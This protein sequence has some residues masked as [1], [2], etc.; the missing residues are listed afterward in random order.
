[1]IRVHIVANKREAIIHAREISE[2]ASIA[3][4]TT[5]IQEH[6]IT[7][8]LRLQKGED[9][10]WYISI[11]DLYKVRGLEYDRWTTSSQAA[12]ELKPEHIDFLN[13][14]ERGFKRNYRPYD[15][16]IQQELRIPTTY[17]GIPKEKMIKVALP[18]VISPTSLP[19][20]SSGMPCALYEFDRVEVKVELVYKLKGVET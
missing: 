13:S 9:V 18:I 5:F 10:I 4:E 15:D 16:V 11:H 7:D 3:G 8:G 14:H 19:N 1:M 2:R 20:Y 17:P 6:R 12:K